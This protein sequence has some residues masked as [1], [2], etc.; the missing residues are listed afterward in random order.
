[1]CFLSAFKSNFS[2]RLR[3]ALLEILSAMKGPRFLLLNG[4]ALIFMAFIL[5][6]LV[7]GPVPIALVVAGFFLELILFPLSFLRVMRKQNEVSQPVYVLCGHCTDRQQSGAGF[8][9]QLEGAA[10]PQ[11]GCTWHGQVKLEMSGKMT[12]NARATFSVAW[13]RCTVFCQ[14][15]CTQEVQAA[16]LPFNNG[17][18]MVQPQPQSQSQ[19]QG[20]AHVQGEVSAGDVTL[21]PSAPGAAA[22]YL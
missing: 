2:T 10:R 19:P 18:G 16:Q 4:I 14:C 11:S 1:V 12:V 17:V 3:A 8:A 13:S 6:L 5:F 15:P 22:S 21:Q 20:V 7:D 9:A